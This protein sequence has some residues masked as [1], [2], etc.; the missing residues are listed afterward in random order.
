MINNFYP[1]WNAS[2]SVLH[3]V[4]PYS[5]EVTEQN[6]IAAYG[7][8]A[9][10]LGTPVR[11]RF[12]YPVYA[13]FPVLPLGL[14]DSRTA[15]RVALCFLVPFVALLVGWLRAAWDGK[16]ALYTILTF[17]SY[18]TIFALQECHPTLLFFG[19]AVGAFALLRSER[20]VL[21]GMVAALAM[22]KPHVAFPILLPMVIW[23]FARW[24]ARKRFVISLV[25]FSSVLLCLSSML[26]PGWT[27]EWLAAV[28]AY[29][30][31]IY[32]S[33]VVLSF[34]QKFGSIV[35]AVLL[36]GLTTVL[37]LDREQ[38]L[39]FQAAI[40]AP[41]TYLITPYVNYNAILLII[42]AVWIAD[43]TDLIKNGG[44]ASQ[45]TLA[46]VRL[47][48]AAFWLTAPVGALLLH[49]TPLGKRT[50]WHLTG[51]MISPLLISIVAV[52]VVQCF[53]VHPPSET[54]LT[55]APERAALS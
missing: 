4:D 33:F 14:L 2:R 53:I 29:S 46:L 54:M 16:T 39:L 8:T 36:V 1:L 6:E 40:C 25:A 23:T 55:D 50:A 26:V 5:P 51:I 15:T 28:R 52:M 37:W 13:T 3:H 22:G 38:D 19:L 12:A 41:V 35:S 30:H 47:A 7:V 48:F 11:Q 18:P 9:K 34:G 31:Y 24:H 21:A 17:A 43:N 32:P 49:T 45:I 27:L 20:L 42:P 44:A 10:V